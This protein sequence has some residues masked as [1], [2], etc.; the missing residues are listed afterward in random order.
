[1]AYDNIV[2]K[3]N[4]L[5]WR[6]AEKHKV[7]MM[8]FYNTTLPRWNVREEKF[9]EYEG[10]RNNPDSLCTDCTSC[11][12]L[13]CYSEILRFAR[14]YSSMLYTNVGGSSSQRVG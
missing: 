7:P 13:A 12:L 9:C 10:R 14:R 8:S 5:L 1:V 3:Q 2:F 11:P 4:K 6:L